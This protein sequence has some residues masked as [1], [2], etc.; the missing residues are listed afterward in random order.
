ME[1]KRTKLRTGEVANILIAE[2]P[3]GAEFG[4]R[5]GYFLEGAETIRSDI[6]VLPVMKGLVKSVHM[7]ALAAEF[8]GAIIGSGSYIRPAKS[9]EIAA[10]GEV[11]T[12]PAHRRKGIALAVCQAALDHFL[13]SGGRAMY[14]GTRNP[15]AE[16]VYRRVGFRGYPKELMQF[17][18]PGSENFVALEVIL[19]ERDARDLVPRL[20]K[21]GASGI[22]TYP[23]NQV[24]P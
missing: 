22:F 5:Y 9:R 12:K 2:S 24:I 8:N 21:A 6:P 11:F 4:G 20:K 7:V 17:L 1:I 13:A 18:A 19:E 16:R 3:V 14:L 23:L 15:A 10:L